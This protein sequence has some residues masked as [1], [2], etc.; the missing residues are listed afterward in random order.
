MRS[1][2]LSL[3][4][5]GITI[6]GCT[7]EDPDAQMMRDAKTRLLESCKKT[8][9]GLAGATQRQITSF[10]TCSTEKT[11][12]ILETE[13]VRYLRDNSDFPDSKKEQIKRAGF[14]CSASILK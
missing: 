2:L 1:F 4:V 11:I 14:S 7:A 12:A 13:G 5:L 8:G 10:C 9:A 6:S 3:F